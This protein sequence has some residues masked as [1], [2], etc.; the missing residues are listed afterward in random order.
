M[1]PPEAAC[2]VTLRKGEPPALAAC[3]P[4]SVRV[5]AAIATAL[6]ANREESMDFISLLK[7]DADA[8]ASAG[9][10]AR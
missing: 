1:S 4:S 9:S 10:Q 7:V 8:P 5:K 6:R 3:G 2:G